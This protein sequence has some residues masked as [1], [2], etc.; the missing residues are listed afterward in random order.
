MDVQLAFLAPLQ[1]LF[2]NFYLADFFDVFIITIFIYAA[3]VLFK[4]TRSRPILAGISTIVL[5]YV[6]ARIF[7]FYL[8]SLLLQSFFGAFLLVLVIIF[9][10]ELRRFFELIALWSTRGRK[11]GAKIMLPESLKL[12]IQAIADLSHRKIGALIVLTGHEN[13]E[14]HIEGGSELDGVISDDV[15]ES[16]FDP[17]S[18]GHDG[19][20]IIARDR[21]S[22]FG[23]HLPLSR[24]FQ[25][26]GK[27]GT[28]HSAALGISEVSDAFA[29]VVSEESG[30]ISFALGGKLATNISIED[31]EALILKFLQEKFPVH[32]SPLWETMIKKNSAEKIFAFCISCALWFFLVYQTGT[33]QRDFIVP[34]SYRNLTKEYLIEDQRPKT[35]TVTLASRGNA[36]DN[37]TPKGLEISIDA[38]DFIG[39]ERAIHITE[40]MITRPPNFSVAN[41]SPPDF[42]IT[43]T[44]YIA[45]EVSINVTT[46]NHTPPGYVVGDI[47]ASP[48]TVKILVSELVKAPSHINTQP[49]DLENVTE[50]QGFQTALILPKGVRLSD[51]ASADV[52]ATIVVRKR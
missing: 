19:A 52:G 36:F 3:L 42:N 27:H 34:I 4:Q 18:P 11:H 43:I 8:T 20:V 40:D 28:R 49:I 22:L 2:V 25:E 16:I 37:F 29:I 38:K 50:T 6:I 9:Q 13:I 26:I 35:I 23:A 33:V 31:V 17:A 32:T 12:I 39:G 7:N 1:T 47:T 15:L 24:N 46:T 21:I 41:I 14:R 30:L 51:E 10:E 44:K 5:L 45:H 48:A